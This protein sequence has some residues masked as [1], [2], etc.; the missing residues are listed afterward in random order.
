MK[1]MDRYIIWNFLVNYLLA[2]SVLVG[3]Y[4]LL[5]II[6]NFDLFT[7]GASY[8]HSGLLSAAAGLLGEIVSFYMYRTLVIFQMMSGV[9]PL[10]AAGFT[11]IRMT[12]H[13]ELTALLAS[14][15]SLYRVAAPVV[16][17]ALGFT[18]LVVLDQEV[19]MPA[20]I[21]KLLRKHGQV[22]ATFVQNE[23][24]YFIPESDHS[25]VLATS[26]DPRT[27]TLR[28]I[29]IIERTA[30]GI[31][32]A[33][34]LAKKA[35]WDPGAGEGPM[36]GGWLMND[37]VQINERKAVDPNRRPEPVKQMIYY[38]PLNPEQLKLMFEKK[39]VDYLSTAQINRMIVVSPPATRAALEKIMYTRISQLVMNMVMLLL[40]IP[41]LLTREPGALVKN[42]FLCSMVS[43]ACFITTFVMYQLAGSGLSPFAGAAAPV[44]LFGPLAVVMLDTL[45]T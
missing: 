6:V 2:L 25:L 7:R 38:T 34:I 41:F 8:I 45:R 42:M 39:A 10:L 22:A 17:C 37:V 24:I 44:I 13:R 31:P 43:G 16:L 21:N 33:R 15:V 1:R 36:R 35:V 23:P 27:K 14:G 20:N 26:Y 29:R 30:A 3:M 40:G 9:I 18:L 19:L 11:M 28:N 32:T 5:D 4:I 12:R